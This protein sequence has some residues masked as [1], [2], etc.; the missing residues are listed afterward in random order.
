[1]DRS[2]YLEF[3]RESHRRTLAEGLADIAHRFPLPNPVI[4]QSR[5]VVVMSSTE[6]V[7]PPALDPEG[8]CTRCQALGTVARVTVGSTPPRSTR[9]CASCWK[10]IRSEYMSIDGPEPAPRKTARDQIAFMDRA[11]EPPRSVESRSWDDA[12]DFLN[13]MMSARE[14][15]RH[16]ASITPAMLAEL[17][18]EIA[19]EAD[20]MDG[21]MP[22]EIEAFVRQ[23]APRQ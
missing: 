21:P 15:P 17:A 16:A 22:P 18:T 20:G 9:F 2:G 12:L 6:F 10:Q 19:A 4:V 5:A 14:D 3:R 11:Q 1:M 7:G 13:L 23:Y 8:V